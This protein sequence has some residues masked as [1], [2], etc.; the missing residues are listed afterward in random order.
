MWLHSYVICRN[1]ASGAG[2]STSSSSSRKSTSGLPKIA[3]TTTR[4]RSQSGSVV[5]GLTRGM[6]PT[7]RTSTVAAAAGQTTLRRQ[8]RTSSGADG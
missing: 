5:T 3:S 2:A 7:A 8:R 6:I 1:R 4:P